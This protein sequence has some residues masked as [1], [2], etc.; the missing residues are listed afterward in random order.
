MVTIVTRGWRRATNHRA[1]YIHGTNDVPEPS[2]PQLCPTR[3]SCLAISTGR[4]RLS[5]YYSD[6]ESLSAQSLPLQMSQSGC[7]VVQNNLSH[8]A[9]EVHS[10]LVAY[11]NTFSPIPR[12]DNQLPLVEESQTNYANFSGAYRSTSTPQ[13]QQGAAVGSDQVY[14][15]RNQYSHASNLSGTTEYSLRD[16]TYR[17][18][19]N[20][21][22]H[23]LHVLNI[24]QL[25]KDAKLN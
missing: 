23:K 24:L 22:T 8:S 7:R 10:D 2:H 3:A 4:D 9:G 1:C 19:V 25:H 15:R 21:K 5:R 14:L 13:S 18:E 16:S 6:H 20:L 12:T 17:Y 11:N